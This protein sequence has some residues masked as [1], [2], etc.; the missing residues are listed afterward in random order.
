MLYYESLEIPHPR[1][2]LDLDDLQRRFYLRSRQLHPDR[3]A[4]ASAAEQQAALEASSILNDAYRTLRDPVRRAEYFLKHHGFD[5]GEQ[6]TKDVPPDLL[7]EVFEL[8]MALEEL[9]MGDDS[10]QPQIDEARGRFEQLRHEIDNQLEEL[11]ARYDGQ[12]E[13]GLLVGIRG[14]LNRRRYVTNLIQ[15][16][17]SLAAPQPQAL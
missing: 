2:S 14:L 17:S 15:T 10:V 11:F 4:R 5:I 1:L 12:A 13:H 6:R 16:A 8:N 9:K 7:E 3:F